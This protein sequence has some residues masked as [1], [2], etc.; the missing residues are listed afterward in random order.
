MYLVR[1]PKCWDY[2]KMRYNCDIKDLL[3]NMHWSENKMHKEIAHEF[4]VSRPTVTRWFKSLN[5][6]TQSC[7]RFTDK[8]LTSW[9]YKT[10]R[11]KKKIKYNGPDR[12]VQKTKGNV[13]IDFFKKWSPEMAYVL[14]F[15]AADGGMFVNSGGSRYLQFTSTDH[16]ILEKIRT[17]LL[18]KQ[19]ISIKK[20]IS[21][22]LKDCFLLQIGSKEIFNDLKSLGFTP[23]K[24][25]TMR[26]PRIPDKYFSHFL[27]GYFDGDGCISRSYYKKKDRKHKSCIVSLI[28]ASGSESF[29]K[30]IS[31]R[32]ANLLSIGKGYLRRNGNSIWLRYGKGEAKIICDFM[33]YSDPATVYFLERK[34]NKFKEIFN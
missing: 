8:N 12:R 21:S 22:N 34:Y 28:F 11:L 14:G 4:G 19:K 20:R 25:L 15:F 6:P 29:L 33:Y 30:E 9:L 32:L 24:E 2:I 13:N 7:R 10:G 16:E 27:R 26:L 23:N 18:A 5:I 17:L 3:Y 31:R 1:G